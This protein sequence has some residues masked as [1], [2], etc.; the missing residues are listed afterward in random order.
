MIAIVEGGMVEGVRRGGIRIG[1]CHARAQGRL[2]FVEGIAYLL[3]DA[4]RVTNVGERDMEGE[5]DGLDLGAIRCGRVGQGRG[6]FRDLARGLALILHIRGIVEAGQG[7]PAEGEG[8]SVIS[9]IAGR[10]HLHDCVAFFL[11]HKLFIL[12]SM[13]ILSHLHN[14]KSNIHIMGQIEFNH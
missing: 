10:G 5:E 12:L 7:R 1:H 14:L 3:G 2:S 4:H 13:G 8:V 6:P 9:G 11:A